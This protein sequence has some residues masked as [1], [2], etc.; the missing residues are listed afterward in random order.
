MVV[1]NEAFVRTYLPNVAPLGQRVAYP[2]ASRD[3]QIVGVVKDAVYETLRV[4]PPP[5]IYMSYLQLRGRPM[6]I[7]V[8][9][10]APMADVMAAVRAAVQPKAPSSPMRVRTFARQIESSLFEARLMR[11]LTSI[12]GVLALALAAVG[13]YGLMSYNVAL[14]TR[15]IGVRLALGARPARVVR[16]VLG[17]AIRMVALGVVIGLPFAWLASRAISRLVFGVT[18]TDPITI[19]AAVAILGSVGI[20]SAAVP[21]R[22]AAAVEPAKAIVVE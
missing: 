16:M 9:A 12:F 14:R 17:S 11:L 1:V 10:S 6:T 19:A 18:P 7:V 4:E 2:G 15:E 8:D 20:A 22:R 21:A 5:T 13:L 3:M